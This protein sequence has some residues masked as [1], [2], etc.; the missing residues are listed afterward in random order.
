MELTVMVKLLGRNIGY[1]ALLNR[2]VSLWKL[3]QP[4]RLMDVANR[5]Y[6]IRFQC[7]VDYDTALS[8]GP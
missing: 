2:I 3:A 7:R 6:L 8:Q 4:F 1:G 5:F